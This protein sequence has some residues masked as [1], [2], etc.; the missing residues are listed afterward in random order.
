MSNPSQAQGA[1]K[2]QRRTPRPRQS[3]RAQ[4]L[5]WLA[6][7]MGRLGTLATFATL[8][9]LATAC[10]PGSHG[11]ASPTRTFSDGN[12]RWT[13]TRLEGATPETQVGW[14]D[15]E[16]VLFIG[17]KHSIDG[18]PEISGL[19]AWNRK[20]PARLVLP[21]AY[22]FCFDG[23]TWTVRTGEPQPGRDDLIYRRYRL[24][25]TDL[26]TTWIGPDQV[27]PSTGYLH[28]YTCSK[29]KRPTPLEAHHWDALR[30]QEGYLDFG[31]DGSFNQEISLISPSL[32]S[33]TPLGLRTRYPSGRITKFSRFTG[34]YI[35]YDMGFSSETLGEWNQTKR[36]P[37]YTVSPKG[38]VHRIDVSAGPWSQQFGGDRSIEIAKTGLGISSKGGHRSR[39]SPSGV[40]LLRQENAY[41]KLDHGIIDSLSASPGGCELAYIQTIKRLEPY[42]QTAN[43]C[44]PT[45]QDETKQ[46]SAP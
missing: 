18:S 13:L 8:A 6:A 40:Y 28:P 26:S 22:R 15:D 37:I 4:S 23:K 20:S 46:S 9:T 7:R 10:R 2:G 34:S 32:K 27:G 14:L 25:P 29:E 38:Y 43:L 3:L 11:N 45:K 1:A 5:A 19:Y 24:N 21:D 41:T 33:Q 35:I 12:F 16:T 17:T 30:P 39:T 31:A 44:L 42:L 36:F